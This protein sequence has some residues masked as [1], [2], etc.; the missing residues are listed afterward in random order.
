MH[1]KKRKWRKNVAVFLF[2]LPLQLLIRSVASDDS[3]AL[4]SD[5]LPLK[6]LS[7]YGC[8]SFSLLLYQL[9]IWK[10]ISEEWLNRTEKK[11]KTPASEKCSICGSSKEFWA[12]FTF[13]LFVFSILQFARILMVLT[14][15]QRFNRIIYSNSLLWV[16]VASSHNVKKK[17]KLKTRTLMLFTEH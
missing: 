13:C 5:S 8:S 17:Q 12:S 11:K 9:I 7:C 3:G 4:E 2:V 1:K 16:Y 10:Q 14:R 6:C 15:L